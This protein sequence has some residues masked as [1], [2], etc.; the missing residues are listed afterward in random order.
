MT[1]LSSLRSGLAMMALGFALSSCSSAPEPKAAHAPKREE[2]FWIGDQV[3]GSPRIV[4]DLTAQRARYYK[5]DKL[6]GVSPI[7]SGREGHA[8]PTGNFKITEKDVYHR[9]SIYGAYL[10]GAGNVVVEDVDV[11]TDPCPAGA[12]FVGAKMHYFMRVVGAVGM[13][14][15]YL[16]GYPASHGCIRLPTRMAATFYHA[17]PYGTPVK[18]VGNGAYAK[19]EAPV[20]ADTGSPEKTKKPKAKAPK[21]K[22][23]KSNVA[24]GTTLY[25]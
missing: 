18:V 3:A 19:Y 25:L 2:A 14:E 16:P 22:S 20:Q 10:D 1:V 23:N 13:H 11:R 9:S 15:G 17:T 7:A 4:I 6:V 21:R 24:P 5:G 12:H 8:T